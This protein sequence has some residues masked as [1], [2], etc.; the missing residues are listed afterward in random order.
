M[1]LVKQ[2][3]LGS[4]GGESSSI[5]WAQLGGRTRRVSGIW[6]WED[7]MRISWGENFVTP[8]GFYWRSRR[9]PGVAATSSKE[10]TVYAWCYVK[11]LIKSLIK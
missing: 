4:D 7:G 8:E 10:L 3:M 9:R 11:R 5:M 2:K 1:G 6:T